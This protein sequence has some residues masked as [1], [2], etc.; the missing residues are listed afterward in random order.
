MLWFPNILN[1]WKIIFNQ[2]VYSIF[3]VNFASHLPFPQCCYLNLS[4]FAAPMQKK[5]KKLSQDLAITLPCTCCMVWLSTAQCGNQEWQSAGNMTSLVRSPLP[6]QPASPFAAAAW[7]PANTELLF[8][9]MHVCCFPNHFSIWQTC[10]CKHV[11]LF[12]VAENFYI[13]LGKCCLIRKRLHEGFQPK[14][15]KFFLS[16]S[17]PNLSLQL[18]NEKLF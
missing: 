6:M 17:F 10:Y 14:P 3:I 7:Q 16:F 18:M 13:P 4:S 15:N 12:R 11:W 1:F 9:I 5:P 8:W 2:T